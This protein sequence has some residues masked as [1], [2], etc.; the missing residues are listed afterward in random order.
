A[1]RPELFPYTTLFRSRRA[2]RRQLISEVAIERAEPARQNDCGDTG[3]VERDD[4]VVDIH[5][6]GR[7]DRRMVEI[8]VFRIDRIIELDGAARDRKSTRLNS[9][10][11]WI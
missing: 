9:S 2:E 11:E 7:L 3:R 8:L 1:A 4:A 10:H 6:V 5:H